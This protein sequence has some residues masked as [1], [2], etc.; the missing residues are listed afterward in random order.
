M[1]S[2]RSKDRARR[3]REQ[4]NQPGGSLSG[5]EMWVSLGASCGSGVKW[6]DVGCVLE[7]ELF[8]LAEGKGAIKGDPGRVARAAVWTAMHLFPHEPRARAASSSD[9]SLG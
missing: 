2:A 5:P 6:A 4:E 7:A 9:L 3:E 1:A 8:G